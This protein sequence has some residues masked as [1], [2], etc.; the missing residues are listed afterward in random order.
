MAQQ[1]TAGRFKSWLDS[2]SPNAGG[3]LYTYVSGTTTHKDAYTT[4]T[5]GTPCTYVN[6]GTGALY[7]ALDARGEAQLWLGSG[8]YTMVEKTSGGSTIDTTDGVDAVGD[9]LLANLADT[10]D[11]AHGDALVGVKITATGGTARTQHAKNEDAYSLKDFGA[12]TGLAADQLSYVNAAITGSDARGRL[13]A[14]AG[15]YLVTAAPTNTYGVQFDGPGRIVKAI[16]GGYQQLNTYADM[17]QHVTGREYLAAMHRR[18]IDGNGCNIV[19]TGDSTTAGTA[20]AGNWVPD[21]L[22]KNIARARGIFYQVPT[23]RGQAGMNS[24]DWVSTYVAGD[25]TN[26]G[27]QPHLMIVRWGINDPYAGRTIAQYVASMRAG[28]ALVRASLTVSQCSILLMAP[29]STSDTPG[30]R[31]ERWYEQVGPALRQI[32]R[33]YQCAFFDTYAW[34]KDSRGAA[35]IWMDDPY[36]DGRAIHPLDVMNAAIYTAVG[37]VIYPSGLA[38]VLANRVQN[39]G[40]SDVTGK[41]PADAVSTYDYGVMWH[42]VTTANGWPLEGCV[43]TFRHRD[44]TYALQ[45]N[46]SSNNSLSDMRWRVGQNASWYGWQGAEQPFYALTDAATIAWDAAAIG[47]SASVTLAGNRTLGAP[48]NLADG[49]ELTLRVLQDAT[50]GR[51]LAYNAIFKWAGGAAPVVTATAAAVTVLCWKYH[52]GSNTLMEIGRYLDVK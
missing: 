30:S 49:A 42:R 28:L 2:G 7:I 26:G 3:R 50:A 14:P 24:G 6:D 15:D 23:N 40:N 5:L 32:A 13:L 8:T 11:V 37:E 52:S 39:L 21:V 41:L 36:A 48:T 1:Y 35:N 51:T 33:E 27:N 12:S 38:P 25:I 45:F 19:L 9:S 10:A 43:L 20:V 31:D 34:C 16:T 46:Y 44:G 17:R 47:H 4:A 18:I 29:N 22:V